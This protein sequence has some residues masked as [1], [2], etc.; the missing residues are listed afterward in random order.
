MSLAD[1]TVPI[2]DDVEHVAIINHIARHDTQYGGWDEWRV[3]CICGGLYKSTTDKWFIPS[4]ASCKRIY[5]AH[6]R[7]VG[8][9]PP[10]DV[11]SDDDE[12][13]AQPDYEGLEVEIV[14]VLTELVASLVE[15]LDGD[16][17]T[18]FT[19]IKKLILELEEQG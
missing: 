18:A 4:E 10:D 14:P 8:V 12:I 5:E 2:A 7:S 16:L 3:A 13:Q 1:L 9:L 19:M 11:S 15:S 17:T 6:L